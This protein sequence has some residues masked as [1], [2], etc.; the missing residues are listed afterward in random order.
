MSRLPKESYKDISSQDLE[1]E[2]KETRRKLVEE[3]KKKRPYS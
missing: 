2:Y 1:Q 3:R